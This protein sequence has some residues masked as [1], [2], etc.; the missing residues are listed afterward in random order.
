[1]T[2]SMDN[3]P[4]RPWV[5]T[6]HAADFAVRLIDVN[7][8]EIQEHIDRIPGYAILSHRWRDDELSFV[9]YEDKIRDPSCKSESD[10]ESDGDLIDPVTPCLLVLR[11]LHSNIMLLSYLLHRHISVARCFGVAVR[12][13]EGLKGK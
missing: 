2:F 4:S 10:G 12:A 1:M 11:R 5:H 13:C 9:N 7:T 3:V 6:S 8:L